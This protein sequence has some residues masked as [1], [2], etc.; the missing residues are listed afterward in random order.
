MSSE[1][2]ILSPSADD[3]ANGLNVEIKEIPIQS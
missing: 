3:E 2:S 1:V